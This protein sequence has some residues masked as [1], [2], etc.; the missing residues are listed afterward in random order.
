MAD[1]KELIDSFNNDEDV[2]T[3]TAAQI[4]GVPIDQVDKDMRRRAK[5]VNFGILYG[6]S[7]HGL[8]A[9]T[10]MTFV[11]AKQFIDKYFELRK[12][13]RQYI[14]NIVEESRQKGYV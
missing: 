12:P 11:E 14:D 5:V 3:K 7:P 13:I 2:H 8:S 1:D 6:M 4:L 9:A 10:G